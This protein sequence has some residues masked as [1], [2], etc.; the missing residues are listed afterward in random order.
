M[1]FPIIGG[2]QSG[3]YLID[4]SVRLN[5]ND[6]AGFSRTNQSS[7]TDAKIF[8][9]SGWVKR[10]NVDTSSALFNG[11]SGNNVSN[12]Y[13]RGSGSENY[14]RLVETS[15]GFISYD[16]LIDTQMLF[17]DVSAWYH[18]VLKY[19]STNGT[20]ND[21]AIIYVNGV[22]VD[23][24]I[25]NTVDSNYTSPLN[26]GSY[27]NYLGRAS[28]GNYLDGYLAEV[29]FIDGQALSPTDFG[30]FDEDSGIWKPIEYTGTYGTNGFYLDFENSGSLGADQSGNGNNFTPTNIVSTDQMIDTPTRN[31]CTMNPLD[32]LN[33]GGANSEQVTSEGNLKSTG[34]GSEGRSIGSTFAITPNGIS[35]AYAEWYS[36]SGSTSKDLFYSNNINGYI[37]NDDATAGNIVMMAVDCVAGKYWFGNNG[38]WDAS[39]DPA[40]GTNPTG[41]FT[42]NSEVQF[43]HRCYDSSRSQVV[44][45]GQD[46]TFA[47]NTTRQ[48]NTDSNGE[49]DFYYA[50]PTGFLSLNS[51]NLSTQAS[52]TIDDGSQYFNTVLYSG[53]GT[54]NHAI[55]G[56]GFQPDL[57]W[58]KMRSAAEW[59]FWVDSNR[60]ANK[61]V[62]SNATNAEYDY[63]GDVAQIIK[64]FDSDGFTLGTSNAVNNPSQT[65]ASW[66]WLAN[67]GTTSSNT[68]GTITSTVQAN[69]TAGF[70]IV[71]YT[72]TQA[73]A[74][75]GHGLGVAP[76]FIITKCRS[77]SNGWPVYHY[78]LSATDFVRLNQTSATATNSVVWNNTEPTS[79]VFTVGAND[80]NNKSGANQLA[81]CFAEIEG[82]SKF[83]KFVGNNSTDGSFCYLGF[84]P[85]YIVIKNID[86]T[87]GW[88]CHDIARNPFNVSDDTHQLQD[89]E[90][91]YVNG[92]NRAID[93]LSNGFKIRH[94][95]TY[96]GGGSG[97][98]Y[99]YMAFAENPF[100]SSTGIPV[101]AR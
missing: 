9:W 17:R 33:I 93:I 3:G 35:K 67:G 24:T 84:R 100:V 96:A 83:G 68:D 4:N 12:F 30:E 60:G 19:D 82:Y 54:D 73:N 55:T 95:D 86:S 74:T 94:T 25:S 31:F 45:F 40:N 88:I 52:P 1:A 69:P 72:G 89:S 7:P 61:A 57:V 58:A 90:A 34:T 62:W 81:Y 42:A 101:T 99:I 64:S 16:T 92:S 78:S 11:A 97:V 37:A 49:G 71:T 70:S 48:N 27:S 50:P 91:E 6:S 5:D 29:N 65:F 80:E 13:F 39:G 76:K 77:A 20:A 26:E 85:Q 63:S 36:V 44:N 8:T 75:V 53:N 43:G 59:H 21:R 28:G 22:Q 47:G 38:T 23:L 41:T 15:D 14:I 46:S 79:T 2:S 56:A 51:L 10:G 18:V 66:N 87:G 98:N 32:R